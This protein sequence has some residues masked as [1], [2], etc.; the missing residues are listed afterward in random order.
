MVRCHGDYHR[1]LRD[2]PW[3]GRAVELRLRVRRFRCS[4]R[5][6]R[7]RTFTE[8]FP[9]VVAA[10]GRATLRLS[11]LIRQAGYAVGGRA[12]SRLLNA[13]GVLTSDD[14]VLRRVKAR[15]RE[16]AEPGLDK[17]RVLGVDD[18]AWHKRQRYGTMLMDLERRQVI[19]LLPVRSADSLAEWLQLH[20]GVEVVARDRCAL[21]ADGTRRGAP[22][23]VQVTDRYHLVSNL[24]E[25]VEIE[26]QQLQVRARS[27]LAR[28]ADRLRRHGRRQSLVEARYQRCRRA[29]YERYLEVVERARRGETQLAIAAELGLAASTVARWQHALSF[30]KGRSGATGAATMHVCCRTL[31][32]GRPSSRERTSRQGEWPPCSFS[33]RES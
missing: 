21:Y 4:N 17:V 23:A 13:C 10:R 33:P 29:R 32:L 5:Q 19:D 18:W 14:T 26:A 7:R 20:P 16:A 31:R 6:C 25:T 27:T 22:R 3:L 8:Q 24:S 12:G 2:L 9:G 11:G 15:P 28:E 30:R 1:R